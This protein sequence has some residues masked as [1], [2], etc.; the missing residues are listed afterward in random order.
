VIS[1]VAS[2][3]LVTTPVVGFVNSMRALSKYWTSRE[4]PGASAYSS[5][6]PSRAS[7][8]GPQKFGV[9]A[10]PAFHCASN[11]GLAKPVAALA[12]PTTQAINA[13]PRSAVTAI[14]RQAVCRR[15]RRDR[16]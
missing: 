6:S 1:S 11:A 12:G 15:S 16:P 5:G 7:E 8:S 4:P 13:T 14:N 2:K 10:S 3:P 9:T